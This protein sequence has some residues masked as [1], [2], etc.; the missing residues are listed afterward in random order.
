MNPNRTEF[1]QIIK[2]DSGIDAGYQHQPKRVTP[3]EPLFT[4]G[5]VLKWY[6]VHPE[7][8]PVPDEISNLAR[9]YLVTTSL[10]AHGMGCVILHRCGADFY[11]LI[12]CTWR[13]S[14]EFGKRFSIKM[15]TRYRILRF[16]RARAATNRRSAFGSW[17]P[18]GTNSRRGCGFSRRRAMKRRLRRGSTIVSQ[19]SL[20]TREVENN[21][22][23]AR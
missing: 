22:I 7:N 10:E 20:K 11:F 18:S 17:F 15:A 9:H 6:A 5:A 8:L 3:F 2:I 1:A 4:S 12:V 16:F 14:N 19:G 21:L 13:N 23:A